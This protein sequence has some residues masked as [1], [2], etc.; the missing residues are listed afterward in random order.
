MYKTQ[1]L[2]TDRRIEDRLFERYRM[3]SIDEKLAHIGALGKGVEDV[4]LA[5]LRSRYPDASEDENRLRLLSRWLDAESMKRIYDW[6]PA[7]R[8]M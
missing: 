3:M 7:E 2:D 1:S 8:G 6:D 5:G 4:A